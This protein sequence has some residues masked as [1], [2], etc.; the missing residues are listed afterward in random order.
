MDFSSLF[1]GLL[2][3]IPLGVGLSYLFTHPEMRSALFARLHKTVTA[4]HDG[5][6]EKLDARKP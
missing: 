2:F 3:G 5:I 4:V 6:V 1:A